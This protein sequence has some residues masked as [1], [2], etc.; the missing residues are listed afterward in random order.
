MTISGALLTG[1]GYRTY[2]RTGSLQSLSLC[3]MPVAV[4]AAAFYAMSRNGI[5][6]KFERG[7]V[8]A[9]SDSG[10]LQWRED[11]TGLTEV[12]C[13]QGRAVTVMTLRW[14]DHK[15][16]MELYDSLRKVLAAHDSGSGSI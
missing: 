13:T 7:S 12:L 10:K 2:L 1:L 8:S 5:W 3:V 6:Y 14:S 16:R 9:F 15:R 11:L 4:I